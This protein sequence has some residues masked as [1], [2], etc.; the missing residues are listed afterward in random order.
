MG[1][2]W[3]SWHLSIPKHVGTLTC[4]LHSFACQNEP[5]NLENGGEMDAIHLL[6]FLFLHTLFFFELYFG[7]YLI[8]TA[9]S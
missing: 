6:R 7:S 3:V 5:K 2:H 4:D 1:N 8:E 9:I